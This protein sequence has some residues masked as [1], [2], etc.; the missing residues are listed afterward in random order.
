MSLIRRA[1]FSLN[2]TA[3]LGRAE[4]IMSD[5]DR[6]PRDVYWRME[7]GESCSCSSVRDLDT[8]A[9]LARLAGLS[10]PESKRCSQRLHINPSSEA[11][12]G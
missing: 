8:A 5:P 6:R 11:F 3:V 7:T 10:S 12:S 2:C 9:K 1:I 4:D